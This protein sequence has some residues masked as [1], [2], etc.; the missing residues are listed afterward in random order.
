MPSL[1]GIEHAISSDGFFD[2][3]SQPKKVAVLGAGYLPVPAPAP[4]PCTPTPPPVNQTFSTENI[5]PGTR[6]MGRTYMLGSR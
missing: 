4:A 2:I 3:E 5:W 1:P 6:Y